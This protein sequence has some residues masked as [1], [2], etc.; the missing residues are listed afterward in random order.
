MGSD[1]GGSE[2]S[3]DWNCTPEP[4]VAGFLDR[5]HRMQVGEEKVG[6]VEDDAKGSD[7]GG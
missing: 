2:K 4:E 1:G 3:V 5:W 6:G 7:P